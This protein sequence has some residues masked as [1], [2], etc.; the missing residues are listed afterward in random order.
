MIYISLIM[1]IA[2]LVLITKSYKSM[3][4]EKITFRNILI[5][6]IVIMISYCMYFMALSAK[7]HRSNDAM[8]FLLVIIFVIGP[9]LIFTKWWFRQIMYNDESITKSLFIK[10]KSDCTEIQNISDEEI[11]NVYLHIVNVEKGDKYYELIDQIISEI[12]KRNIIGDINC[13]R[14]LNIFYKKLYLSVNLT[15]IYLSEYILYV[16]K[17][18]TK[19]VLINIEGIT[20]IRIDKEVIMWTKIYNVKI[21]FLKNNNIIETIITFKDSERKLLEEFKAELTKLSKS[22]IQ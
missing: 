7:L 15:E 10:V 9:F 2:I 12:I 8:I 17:T 13:S 18:N 22:I 6:S 20:E 19:G 16:K 21:T 1:T 4:A 5:I 3:N 14:K 11:I